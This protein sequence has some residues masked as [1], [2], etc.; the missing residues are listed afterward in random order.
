MFNLFKS[1]PQP[2]FDDVASDEIKGV[3]R[4][5][6]A[7]ALSKLQ[8]AAE[9]AIIG[10]AEEACKLRFD[11]DKLKWMAITIPLDLIQYQEASDG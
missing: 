6:N 7:A 4:L 10:N 2:T 3:R 9:A 1:K 11:A 8:D 5:I